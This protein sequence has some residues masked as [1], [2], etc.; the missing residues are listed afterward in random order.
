MNIGKEVGD[1]KER[2][3]P[4]TRPIVIDLF[5]GSGNLMFH[6]ANAVNAAKTYGFEMDKNVYEQTAQNFKVMN[7]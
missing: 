6:V 2:F 3:F 4:D 1:M 5:T 7:F